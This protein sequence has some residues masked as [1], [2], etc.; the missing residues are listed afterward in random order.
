MK[1]F[2][3][4][5]LFIAALLL[6]VVVSIPGRTEDVVLVNQP[7]S[8]SDPRYRYGYDLLALILKATEAEFGTAR[9][10]LSPIKMVRTRTLLELVQGK[11]IHVM[12]EAPKPNWDKSLLPV[13]IPIRKGVQG[14]RIFLIHHRNQ[15]LL[16]KVDSLTALMELPTGSGQQWS[17]RK[18]MEQAGFNVISGPSYEG[19]FGMLNANRFM[20]FGRG[21]NEA[22]RELETHAKRYPDLKVEERLLLYIPLP[23]Y[24]Y[25]T[26][27]RPELAERIKVGFERLIDSGEFDRFFYSYHCEDIINSKLSGRLVFRINNSNI[28]SASMVGNSDYWLDPSSDFLKL[29]KSYQITQD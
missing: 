28:D 7:L 8:D 6:G 11:N 16:D 24:F 29:C 18:V 22:Y 14:F 26:P 2:C 19:L 4:R 13:T 9:L 10:D 1:C 23:T 17:T 20:T 27:K 25:V 21:I 5:S 12:A 15:P 3:R